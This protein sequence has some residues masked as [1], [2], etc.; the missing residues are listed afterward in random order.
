[1][2]RDH[3]K[4]GGTH[5]VMEVTSEGIHQGRVSGINYDVKIL[6]NITEDHLDY[7]KTFEEYKK[8]KLGF[9]QEGNAHKIY[10]KDFKEEPIEFTT[11]LLG[12]FNLS[13][14]KAAASA[15]RYMEISENYIQNTLSVCAAPKGRL[16]SITAGQ[17]YRVLVDYAHTADGLLNVLQTLKEVTLQRG[18]HLLVLFGCGGDRDAAKRPKMGKIASEISDFWVLTDD[19]PRS[20]Q[21][22]NIISDI[23]GGIAPKSHKYA[24]IPDRKDAINFIIGKAQKNDVVLLAGKGHET[25]QVRGDDTTYFDDCEEALIAIKTHKQV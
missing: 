6:T 15:L 20:E 5:F 7:H 8:V 12:K 3:I 17:A 4:D 25:Y 18:G 16:E 11:Q 24:V 22:Q 19:N 23:L 14:I 21:S 10:P 9:M 2:M 1:M 13:N